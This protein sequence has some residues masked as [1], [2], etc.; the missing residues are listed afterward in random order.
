MKRNKGKAAARF[1]CL[2]VILVCSMAALSGCNDSKAEEQYR[3][4]MALL[5]NRIS[6]I[7]GVLNEK[8]TLFSTSLA[9]EDRQGV[10]TAVADLDEGYAAFLQLKAPKR[11]E[12]AQAGLKQAVDTARQGMEIYRTEFRSVNAS[13]FDDAFAQAVTEGDQLVKQAND[14]IAAIQKSLS[15]NA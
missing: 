15:A 4:D 9:E 2:M 10:L 12:D 14:S 13:T 5:A 1:V 6:E 7:S 11:Y 3:T 8:V